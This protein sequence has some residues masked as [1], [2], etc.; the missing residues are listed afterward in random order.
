MAKFLENKE[1]SVATT[2][3]NGKK[4]ENATYVEHLINLAGGNK[5]N[6]IGMPIPIGMAE[7]RQRNRLL[8]VLEASNGNIILED[9]DAKFLQQIVEDSKWYGATKDIERMA[10]DVATMKEYKQNSK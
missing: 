9:A 2:D 3:K 8:D 1:T 6:D 4:I 5:T 7:I 10:D